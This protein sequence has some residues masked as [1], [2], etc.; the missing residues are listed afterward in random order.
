ML[1]SANTELRM[2]LFF[3]VHTVFAECTVHV[4]MYMYT[5]IVTVHG[6]TACPSKRNY[7]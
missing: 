7:E 1:Y 4:L 3:V 5:V 6:N 2:N